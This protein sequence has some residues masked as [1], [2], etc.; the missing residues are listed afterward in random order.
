MFITKV[1]QHVPGGRCPGGLDPLSSS[2][3][4][5]FGLPRRGLVQRFGQALPVRAN[6]QMMVVHPRNC[7]PE[8]QLILI[9]IAA[10]GLVLAGLR[11][12]RENGAFRFA[13]RFSVFCITAVRSAKIQ[14]SG[15]GN[16][17]HAVEHQEKKMVA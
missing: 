14:H 9:H 2:G 12:G 11:N 7:L 5:S 8:Q 4:E 3:P 1:F 10:E 6:D 13:C 17:T 16:G 15:P